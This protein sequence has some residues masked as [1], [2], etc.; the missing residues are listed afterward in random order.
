[1]IYKNITS[2][3]KKGKKDIKNVNLL[4]DDYYL[5]SKNKNLIN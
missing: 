4:Y 1:M 5:N 3:N 2:I